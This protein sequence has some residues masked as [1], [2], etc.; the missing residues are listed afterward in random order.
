MKRFH[1]ALVQDTGNP[2]AWWPVVLERV[3]GMPFDVW[4]GDAAHP[5]EIAAAIAT[6][7]AKGWNDRGGEP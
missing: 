5:T 2:N 3:G 6:A 1:A 7:S 4:R